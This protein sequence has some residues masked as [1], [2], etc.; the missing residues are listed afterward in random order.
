M[1]TLVFRVAVSKT[2][3]VG[4]SEVPRSWPGWAEETAISART[5]IRPVALSPVSGIDSRETSK[6]EVLPLPQP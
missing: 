6:T 2:S 1:R 3:R 4:I 5:W